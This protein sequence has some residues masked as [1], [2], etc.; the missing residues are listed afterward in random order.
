M[1]IV[2]AALASGED[3]VPP[4]G[5]SIA[6]ILAPTDATAQVVIGQALAID[7]GV[8]CTTV[9]DGETAWGGPYPD[10]QFGGKDWAIYFDYTIQ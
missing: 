2:N 6:V 4:C 5:G 8:S 1:E 3:Y 9:F 7:V 10:T